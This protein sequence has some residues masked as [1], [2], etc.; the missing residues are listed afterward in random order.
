M[1]INLELSVLGEHFC[2]RYSNLHI[3]AVLKTEL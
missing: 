1:Y 3:Y 2:T